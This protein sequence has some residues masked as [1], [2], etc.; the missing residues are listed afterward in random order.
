MPGN[1]L[2]I[3]QA[4]QKVNLSILNSYYPWSFMYSMVAFGV[5]AIKIWIQVCKMCCQ[6][7]VLNLKDLG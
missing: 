4:N 3:F 2:E 5:G 6:R 7:Y 1:K